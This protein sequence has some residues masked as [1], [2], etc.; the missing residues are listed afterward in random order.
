[1]VSVTWRKHAGAMLGSR[2]AVHVVTVIVDISQVRIAMVGRRPPP[3]IGIREV[4]VVVMERECEKMRGEKW[5]HLLHV[6]DAA[7]VPVAD[8][9]V[10]RRSTATVVDE[11]A[12]VRDEGRLQYQTR[13]RYRGQGLSLVMGEDV[14]DS[15]EN[16]SICGSLHPRC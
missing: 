8:V 11:V 7:D 13:A 10:E 2:I 15:M 14:A 3:G 5:R 12:H 1:M 9:A 6:G 4:Q 16:G